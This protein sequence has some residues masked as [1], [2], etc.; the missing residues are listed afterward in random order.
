MSEVV[1]FDGAW[2]AG[3]G[4]R[5]FAAD[6]L[7]RYLARLA[8]RKP[9][10]RSQC[11]I[12][13]QQD[14]RIPAQGYRIVVSRSGITIRFGDE[15]GRLNGTYGLLETLGCRWFVPGDRGELVPGKQLLCLHCGELAA[16]P[17]HEAI[18]FIQDVTTLRD[19]SDE[20]LV[21][22]QWA[23][24]L[25]L[26]DWMGRN[27]LT[28][29]RGHV[30]LVEQ[31]RGKLPQAK[32]A[33]AQRH[34]A[35]E[36]GGH[37][38]SHLL[39]RNLFEKHPEYF[40]VNAAGLRTSRGNVCVSNRDALEVIADNARRLL[41]PA[42][43]LHCWGQD[44]SGGAWCH[45][46]KCRTLPVAE[47]YLRVV[48]RVADAVAESAP[49]TKVAYI[50]Y[51]DT[52]DANLTSR[53]RPNVLLLFAPR[54]R[55]YAHTIDESRCETNRRHFES[56]CRYREVFKAVETFEYYGD[57]L[58]YC[59]SNASIPWTVARDIESYHRNG[60]SR[61]GCLMFG[62]A[63]W[64]FA[65]INLYVF[66]RKSWDVNADADDIV[67]Q[68]CD[69]FYPGVGS[70]MLGYHRELEEAMGL[71]LETSDWR[72]RPACFDGPR[73]V[74][75][76]LKKLEE[77]ASRLC[78]LLLSVPTG[79]AHA[80]A[81]EKATLDLTIL[82]VRSFC[83]ELQARGTEGPRRSVHLREART[84]MSKY[85]REIVKIPSELRGSWCSERNGELRRLAER[86][87]RGS[88]T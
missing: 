37:I 21:E 64:L 23:D 32:R 56:F 31:G 26:F 76:A 29:L 63:A 18:T 61:S 11:P 42:E 71:L 52:L 1:L 53:P 38:I 54:S 16:K 85:L 57:C 14:G 36:I 80:L 5:G 83:R 28:T 50:A 78:E 69:G 12:R 25:A 20:R 15:K 87:N 27:R 48:N 72:Y 40:P 51:Y 3:V 67:R 47:Q 33:M 46:E 43:V 2:R 86:S 19:Y 35:E 4:E 44:V 49:G 59:T 7:R 13:F 74:S 30:G 84:L 39:P 34:I 88:R 24:D 73:R 22:R 70:E 60:V 62:G 58:L 68:F 55:C 81:L 41:R 45:C 8:G 82:N 77:L 10:R 6:E 17:S 65:P 79:S 66:A 75:L 9:P